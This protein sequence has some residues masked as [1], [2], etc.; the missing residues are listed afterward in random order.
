MIQPPTDEILRVAR[1]PVLATHNEAV[2][3]LGRR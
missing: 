2:P 3:T 1:L